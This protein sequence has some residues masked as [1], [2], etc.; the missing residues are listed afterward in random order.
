MNWERNLLL[1]VKCT[2]VHALACTGLWNWCEHVHS[3]CKTGLVWWVSWEERLRWYT[4]VYTRKNNSAVVS[5][6]FL[7]SSGIGV[8][9]QVGSQY[10]T[11]KIRERKDKKKKK[12][13]RTNRRTNAWWESDPFS[14][15]LSLLFFCCPNLGQTNALAHPHH[16]SVKEEK[17]RIWQKW[18]SYMCSSL[19]I[20][21]RVDI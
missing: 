16:L 15:S 18:K 17:E 10:G 8:E 3:M 9:T 5:S 4:P 7:Y 11:R 2:R 21:V 1:P 19:A 13:K 20:P 6:L 14:L 12:Q